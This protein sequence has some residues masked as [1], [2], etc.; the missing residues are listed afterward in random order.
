MIGAESLFRLRQ[1]VAI[2]GT[3][4]LQI[5]DDVCGSVFGLEEDQSDVLADNAQAEELNRAHEEDDDQR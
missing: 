1:C 2:I 3:V 5:G 4:P